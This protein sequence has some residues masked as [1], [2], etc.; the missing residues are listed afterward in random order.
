MS[1]S[2]AANTTKTNDKITTETNICEKVEVI[3]CDALVS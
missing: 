2:L 3:D 1:E